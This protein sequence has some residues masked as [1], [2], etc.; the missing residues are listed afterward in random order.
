[1]HNTTS[2][3]RNIAS[4]AAALLIVLERMSL[5]HI[6]NPLQ[7]SHKPVVRLKRQGNA[8]TSSET[9][10]KFTSLIGQDS[11]RHCWW[12]AKLTI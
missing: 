5:S 4:N 10:S 8:L 3:T 2:G 9:R 11:A 1:M 7:L 12:S 6:T